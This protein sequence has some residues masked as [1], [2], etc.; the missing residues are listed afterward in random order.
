METKHTLF[1]ITSP[2]LFFFIFTVSFSSLMYAE[3]IEKVRYYR[4]SDETVI[5]YYDLDVPNPVNITLEVSLNGGITFDLKPTALSGDIGNNVFPG[6]S[7]RIEWDVF[8]DIDFLP[9]DFIARVYTGNATAGITGNDIIPYI[10]VKRLSAIAIQ[11]PVT[12]DGYLTEPSWKDAPAASGFTQQEP[13]EGIKASEQTEVR[14]LYDEEYLYIGVICF[15]AE[16]SKIICN[17]LSVDGELEWDDNFSIVIDTF[18][19]RRGGFYFCINPNGARLDGK[20]TGSRSTGRKRSGDTRRR[21]D[22][23][24]D[25]NGIWDVAANITDQGWSAE[26]VIPFKT[27]R[28]SY[29]KMQEWGIN[30]KRD[31]ARK[32]EQALWTSWRRDDGLMQLTRAGILYNLNDIKRGSKLE[33]IPYTFAGVEKDEGKKDNNL[34]AGVDIKYPLTSDLTLDFTTYTDFAQIEADQTMINLTRF[35][36]RYPEKRGFFLEGAEIFNFSSIYT[37]PFNSREIGITPDRYPVPILAGSKLTGKAGDYSLGLLV[38]QTD[39]DDVYPST[40]YSVV[41]IKKDIFEKSYFGI[42]ATNL[43]DTDKHSDQSFGVDFSYKTDT[44][45]K[46]KNFELSTDI[47]ENKSGADNGTRAGRFMIRYPNDLLDLFLYYKNVGENYGP[48]MGFIERNGI[49]QYTFRSAISP[50]P[51]LPY[52]KQLRFV[53]M[54]MNVYNDMSGRIESREIEI[55][56]LGFTLKTEDIFSFSLLNSLEYLAEEFNIFNDINIPVG[57]YEWWNYATTFQT[58]PNRRVSITALYQWGDFYNGT[59]NTAETLL[60]VKFN[61]YFSITS[62]IAYNDLSINSNKFDTR[63]YNIRLNSNVSTRLNARTYFQW[64]NDD[65][66]ANLNFRIHYIPKIG[67]DIYVVYNHLLDGFQNYKTTYNTAVCKIAYR[68]TF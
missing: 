54:T 13:I 51:E 12:F 17:E 36:I 20:L 16:P 62:D 42:I 15:D 10:Q 8:K 46:N 37:T 33:L 45:L 27:L 29:D 65:K 9:E 59:K 40:N 1:K 28:F 47:T 39:N 43:Y 19:D 60:N 30:F 61:K 34:K 22:I 14:I 53:P 35:N 67:S 32:N 41:R 50:R 58:N 55:S 26:I 7:K 68:I 25:W 63:E 66:L 52:I 2:L 18:N 57:E 31:I 23:N 6:K 3:T 49:Q 21:S 56:P 4:I 5:V 64:N 38:M 24:L 44:F 11:S 48:E